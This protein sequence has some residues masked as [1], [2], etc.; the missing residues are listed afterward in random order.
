MPKEDAGTLGIAST[1]LFGA[2]NAEMISKWLRS[3]FAAVNLN[4]GGA[5]AG[6]RLLEH[7]ECTDF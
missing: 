3:A 1:P 4:E 2:F 6:Q 5:G 7:L